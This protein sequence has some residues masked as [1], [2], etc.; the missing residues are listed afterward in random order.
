MNGRRIV[1]WMVRV[2]GVLL[3]ASLAALLVLR[4]YGSRRLAAAQRAFAAAV[5]PTKGDPC[6]LPGIPA[7][8][9]AAVFLQAGIDAMIFLGHDVPL[10]DQLSATPPASWTE[11]QRA[12]LRRIV[13]RNAPAMELLHRAVGLEKSNFGIAGTAYTM[14]KP[15]PLPVLLKAI[16]VQ[17]LLYD[18]A[19]L[20]LEQGDPNR[21][22]SSV[23][24]MSAMA[25]ALEREPLLVAELVGIACEK[26]FLQV[27]ADAVA[28]PEMDRGALAG[29]ERQLG[30]VDL[31]RAWK[32]TL[33]CEVRLPSHSNVAEGIAAPATMVQKLRHVLLADYF[34]APYLERMASLAGAIEFPYGAGLAGL[35]GAA[36]GRSS[37]VLAR[38]TG[39]LVNAM[40]RFQTVASERRLAR[41]A[42]ALRTYGLE[43]GTYPTSLVSFPDASPKDPFTGGQIGYTLRSDGSAQL[44]V[45][46]GVKL[47]DRLNPEVH[48]PGP[49]TWE[50]PAPPRAAKGA[51]RAAP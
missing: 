3:V 42:L 32:R 47:W 39:N 5:G 49:F 31:G 9:N 36:P 20:A 1:R 18:D 6:S 8:E 15:G 45:P 50:L 22:L 30:E 14:A 34:D 43:T 16:R 35:G 13:A 24:V 23:E 51:S 28:L 11:T 38:V 27:T 21:A 2:V 46:D 29:V 44:T 17:R 33:A 48:N 19:V 10:V 12:D 25:A 40:G 4:I 7:A 26:M 37:T 41:L